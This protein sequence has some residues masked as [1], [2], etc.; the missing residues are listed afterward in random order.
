M[1]KQLQEPLAKSDH[2]CTPQIPGAAAVSYCKQCGISMPASG[3]KFYRSSAYGLSGG[4]DQAGNL[5]HMLRKQHLN[6]FY[7]EEATH[8]VIR[9]RIVEFMRRAHARFEKEPEVFYKALAL[10]DSVFSRHQVFH[11]RVEVVVLLCLHL[12][13]KFDEPFSKY[14]PEKSFFRFAMRTNSFKDLCF[15]E[16]QLIRI[17]GFQLDVQTPFHFLNF[18]NSRGLVSQKDI[19]QLVKIYIPQVSASQETKGALS[20][21]FCSRFG[22]REEYLERLAKGINRVGLSLTLEDGTAL[23]IDLN[24]EDLLEFLAFIK[25]EIPAENFLALFENFGCDSVESVGSE[26]QKKPVQSGLGIESLNP[27]ADLFSELSEEKPKNGLNSKYEN[28]KSS[29]KPNSKEDVFRTLKRCYND[30]L[31]GAFVETLFIKKTKNEGEDQVLADNF[32]EAFSTER[33]LSGASALERASRVLG[34]GGIECNVGGWAK[35]GSGLLENG[36]GKCAELDETRILES[37]NSG[38]GNVCRKESR[39]QFESLLNSGSIEM[40]F[41]QNLLRSQSFLSVKSINEDFLPRTSILTQTE[42]HRQNQS[43]KF[44]GTNPTMANFSLAKNLISPPK[45]DLITNKNDIKYGSS[46]K[47]TH[48]ISMGFDAVQMNLSDLKA[49]H[50]FEFTISTRLDTVGRLLNCLRMSPEDLP[51]GLIEVCCSNFESVFEVLLAGSAEVY[52]LNKFTSAAVA[53]SILYLTRKLMSFPDV[54]P[55]ELT[56]LTGLSEADI[57]GCVEHIINEPRL[58]ELVYQIRRGFE[59]NDQ[60]QVFGSR[61]LVSFRDMLRMYHNKTQKVIADFLRFRKEL[62]NVAVLEFCL[63][64]GRQMEAEGCEESGKVGDNFLGALI[65]EDS[66]DVKEKDI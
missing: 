60:E 4:I 61:R 52:S 62:V 40:S 64:L 24:S 19:A 11:D 35:E 66:K 30:P 44:P 7:N 51:V 17:L 13:A 36:E 9:Q 16:K 6:R 31:W 45:M 63:D 47:L 26:K 29:L 39:D 18:F 1:K 54:W 59:A 58:I 33:F 48:S 37:I 34:E 56:S 32:E 57:Q 25:D 12:A 42:N 15:M 8:R 14:R 46:P 53:V 21:L 55:A 65:E 38:S 20:E 49:M 3:M 27:V 28:V 22:I 23:G 10:V 2:E 5:N 43:F 50:D 41:N